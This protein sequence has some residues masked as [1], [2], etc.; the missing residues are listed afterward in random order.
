MPLVYLLLFFQSLAPILAQQMKDLDQYQHIDE[1]LLDLD[2]CIDDQPRNQALRWLDLDRSARNSRRFINEPFAFYLGDI[3]GDA[4]GV[5][6]DGGNREIY[7]FQLRQCS[8][9]DVNYIFRYTYDVAD[10]KDATI[11]DRKYNSFSSSLRGYEV[12][13]VREGPESKR[14]RE[15]ELDL[16][17]CGGL[18]VLADGRLIQEVPKELAFDKTGYGGKVG[19]IV[20]SGA[21]CLKCHTGV[22]QDFGVERS[23]FWTPSLKGKP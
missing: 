13:I 22:S 17:F 11:V 3:K 1:I 8:N 6:V 12:F 16:V 15:T 20:T 10:A 9:P 18:A 7:W 5:V 14:C 21:G 19:D 2:V 23:D 4:S